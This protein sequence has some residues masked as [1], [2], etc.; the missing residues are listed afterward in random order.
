MRIRELARAVGVNVQTIRFYER[1]K[2][3]P[4]PPR[5]ASGYRSYGPADLERLLFI[6]RNH[7]IGF[8]LAEV[9][10]LLALHGTLAALPRPLRGK[11]AQV[12]DIVRLGR[13]R[14][15]QVNEKIA[16]LCEMKAQLEFM[17][18]HLEESAPTTC[19]V[20]AIE[21]Q[22]CPGRPTALPALTRTAAPPSARSTRP[23]AR[24]TA[25]TRG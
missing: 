25:R 7:Q 8:T 9:K 17:V 6:R 12:S 22:A 1:Q 20:R 5:T 15:A 4:P 18:K 21:A 23:P 13:E 16:V 10:Q 3:L 11:P 14:L 19:P 2:L 24:A